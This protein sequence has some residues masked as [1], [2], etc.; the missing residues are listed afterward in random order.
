MTSQ[1]GSVMAY[2]WTNGFLVWIL[3]QSPCLVTCLFL[4]ALLRSISMNNL[5]VL[6]GVLPL[7]CST[8]YQYRC[9]EPWLGTPAAALE[10]GDSWG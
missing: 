4:H 9:S 6:F 1:Y 7:M 8:K 5:L 10:K 2:K 3:M